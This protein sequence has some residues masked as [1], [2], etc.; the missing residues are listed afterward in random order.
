[1]GMAHTLVGANFLPRVTSRVFRWLFPFLDGFFGFTA[2]CFFQWYTQLN[3]VRGC[4]DGGI[5]RVRISSNTMS[6]LFS[7]GVMAIEY[8]LGFP[9]WIGIYGPVFTG[10]IWVCIYSYEHRG[11]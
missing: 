11:A 9:L 8:L 1:M 10:L 3:L 7:V 5:R 6:A 4:K 2:A